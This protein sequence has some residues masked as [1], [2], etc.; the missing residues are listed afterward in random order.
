MGYTVKTKELPRSLMLYSVVNIRNYISIVV[1]KK[2][3]YV[4]YRIKKIIKYANF[5]KN[6]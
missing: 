2:L 6:Q 4:Y 5:L 3:L 1:L